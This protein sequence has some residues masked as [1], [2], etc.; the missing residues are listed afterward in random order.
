MSAV[1]FDPRYD[2][3]LPDGRFVAGIPDTTDK[4]M[5][6]TRLVDAY[7]LANSETD[8][9]WKTQSLYKRIQRNLSIDDSLLLLYIQIALGIVVIFFVIKYLNSKRKK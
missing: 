5:F 9:Y 8:E 3:V 1:P 4:P 2:H 6:F 7:H